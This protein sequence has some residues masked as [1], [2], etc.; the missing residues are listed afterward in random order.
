MKEVSDRKIEHIEICCKEDVE[1][2]VNTSG[3]E[4]VW[5]VHRAIPEVELDDIELQTNFLG[6]RLDAPLLISAMTG[7]HPKVKEINEV[8]AKVAGELNIAMAV[9]SQRA[10]IID[11][12]LKGTF[13]VV[14]DVAPDAFIMAN[15]GAVQLVS[16]LKVEDVKKAVDM[17]EANAISVHLNP[18]HE[19]SQVGGDT[20]FKGV[21]EAI[22]KLIHELSVPVVVKETG[23]GI[24]Y[25]DAKLLADIGVSAIDVAGA[26]GTSWPLVEA[27]RAERNGE[28]LWA[29]V[30][31]GFAEWGIPTAVS[32]VEVRSVF[33]REVIASGGVRSG[34]DCAKAIALGADLAG[35]ALPALRAASRGVKELKEYV[36]VVMNQLRGAM[37]LTGSRN[38]E[39]LKR[40][41]VVIT[42]R[43]KQWL[44]A[45]GFDVK[46]YARRSFP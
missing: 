10:A 8:L 6:F 33:N 2:R 25:E 43:V 36:S 7:G 13:T 44:E 17:I 37:L 34:L 1:M 29:E 46:S 3:F 40:A 38:I 26:G 4:D 35:F 42:G 16:D 45:R 15:I 12:S 19:F 9:G 18:A 27:L 14:R 31:R 21:L 22:K 5:L 30:A 28:T 41:K 39:E 20:K 11:T 24:S 32:I 23:C